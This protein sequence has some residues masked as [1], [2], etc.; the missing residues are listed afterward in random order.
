MQQFLFQPPERE[1]N[2]VSILELKNIKLTCS[3]PM[4]ALNFIALLT[5][6]VWW[7]W[8]LA[9]FKQAKIAWTHFLSIYLLFRLKLLDG[10]QTLVAC[11]A[12][13]H[14]IV[15]IIVSTQSHTESK[16]SHSCPCPAQLLKDDFDQARPEVYWKTV[17]SIFLIPFLLMCPGFGSY[18]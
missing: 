7:E 14:Y 17:V 3:H 9:T 11:R 1:V 16:W 15:C 12:W 10:I 4:A 5:E 2:T 13:R 6:M 18:F 8:M